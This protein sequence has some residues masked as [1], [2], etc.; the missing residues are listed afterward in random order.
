M[1]IRKKPRKASCWFINSE[2][3]INETSPSKIIKELKKA[4]AEMEKQFK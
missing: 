2:L 1:A 3:H 4:T